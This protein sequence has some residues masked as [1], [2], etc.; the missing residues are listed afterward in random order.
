MKQ[1]QIHREK[2]TQTND[3]KKA[4]N[5]NY[6]VLMLAFATNYAPFDLIKKLV[7]K[8][9]NAKKIV[10]SNDVNFVSSIGGFRPYHLIAGYECKPTSD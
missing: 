4:L 6:N 7:E 10:I 2:Y 1:K 8:N 5:N 9:K 3:F